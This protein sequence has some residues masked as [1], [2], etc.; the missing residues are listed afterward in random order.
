MPAVDALTAGGWVPW[1]VAFTQRLGRHVIATRDIAVGE[2]LPSKTR[3][4]P[5]TPMA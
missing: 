1:T 4:T 3:S 5:T 2:H